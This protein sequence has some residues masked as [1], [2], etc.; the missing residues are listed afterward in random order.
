MAID[1]PRERPPAV[2]P[3]P[4]AGDCPRELL[5]FPHEKSPFGRHSFSK[6]PRI[7][8]TLLRSARATQFRQLTGIQTKSLWGNTGILHFCVRFYSIPIAAHFT[9]L[10]LT[11]KMQFVLRF[12]L[13]CA[14]V[15][16]FAPSTVSRSATKLGYAVL[17]PAFANPPTHLDMDAVEGVH[18]WGGLKSRPPP[19]APPPPLN[20]T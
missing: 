14:S 8:L 17:I 7:Q 6:V 20:N 4:H 2:S 16:A 12:A 18:T 19:V 3:G 10:Q 15:A 9:S 5:S 13:A 1:G 11:F